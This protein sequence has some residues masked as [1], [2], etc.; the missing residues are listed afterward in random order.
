MAQ[1]IKRWFTRTREK[2]RRSEKAS[3]FKSLHLGRDEIRIFLLEPAASYS[4]D[5]R[6]T[7]KHVA[8]DD[9]QRKGYSFAALSYVWGDR[10][11]NSPIHCGSAT[12]FVTTNGD[13]ALRYL[14]KP[15]ERVALWVD[16]ICI[17]QDDMMERNHQV[18][19]MGRVY[20]LASSVVIWL[21]QGVGDIAGFFNC[22]RRI[23]PQMKENRDESAL[24]GIV[25]HDIEQLFGRSC[26]ESSLLL[27]TRDHEQP[28]T[29]IRSPLRYV[30]IY[31]LPPV[32]IQT[33]DASRTSTG[34]RSRGSNCAVPDILAR[35]CHLFEL[36]RP[37]HYPLE[38]S[39]YPAESREP[40][41]FGRNV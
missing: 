40:N 4:A 34:I 37:D 9:V 19:L 33:M 36:L 29:V 13:S 2:A 21:G 30:R 24:A 22:V 14:R 17:N 7:F 5:L 1:T 35:L 18:K 26:I 28:L 16:A 3:G 32:A 31:P 8:L 15:K 38:G 25:R 12:H 23:T 39:V 20:G 11:R 6:G 41:D 27:D 10:L